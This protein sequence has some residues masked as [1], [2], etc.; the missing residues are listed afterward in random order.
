MTQKSVVLIHLAPLFRSQSEMGIYFLFCIW[1]EYLTLRWPSNTRDKMEW[2]S[3]TERLCVCWQKREGALA[4]AWPHVTEVHSTT[5]MACCVH[6]YKKNLQFLKDFVG[7]AVE[8]NFLT[9]FILLCMSQGMGYAV[10]QLVEALRYKLE[11]RGF[12]S[13]WCHWNFSLT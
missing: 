5:V 13:R 9:S 12:D 8:R 6:S 1:L 11:G 4:L 7:H 10:A 2:T 3:K